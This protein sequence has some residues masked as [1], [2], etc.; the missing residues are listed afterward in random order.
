MSSRL[1][2]IR[3]NSGSGKSTI[4]NKL[5]NRIGRR[6]TMVIPLDTVRRE[7][8]CVEDK[9]Y[10]PVIQ[11]IYDMAMY[12]DKLGYDVIVEGIL[13]KKK[14]GI[15]LDD[16]IRD[17]SGKS[18][19]YYLDISFDETL[20]RHLTKPKAHEFGELEMREWWKEKD[21]LGCEK[22]QIITDEMSE[23]DIIDFITCDLDG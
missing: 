2:I 22:E 21:Y 23:K 20:R 5:R 4:A 15:M 3:G 13:S 11:M 17:F 1:I 16:L 12:G 7:I 19:V 14:Y 8:F 18:Y 6:K 10:N 9:E